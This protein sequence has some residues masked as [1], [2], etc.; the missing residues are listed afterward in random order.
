VQLFAGIGIDLERLYAQAAGS[1]F[2]RKA[3][4]RAIHELQVLESSEWS[5]DPKHVTLCELPL[6][7]M[8]DPLDSRSHRDGECCHV[9]GRAGLL[10]P[11][12]RRG[13]VPCWHRLSS[14]GGGGQDPYIS[15]RGCLRG[16]IKLLRC[17]C[18]SSLEL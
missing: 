5:R 2:P 14:V 6:Y 9:G 18:K 11:Y 17:S 3:F 4:W 7:E 13:W 10:G 16:P 12:E 8:P 15:L 1:T